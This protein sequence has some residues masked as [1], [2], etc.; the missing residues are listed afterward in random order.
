[1]TTVQVAPTCKARQQVLGN[2]SNQ[3]LNKATTSHVCQF[4]FRYTTQMHQL[5]LPMDIYTLKATQ[6]TKIIWHA[7]LV[8]ELIELLGSPQRPPSLIFLCKLATKP[9]TYLLASHATTGR[10]RPACTSITCTATYQER[11][12]FMYNGY[13]KWVV[14]DRWSIISS[15]HITWEYIMAI[16]FQPAPKT[17]TMEDSKRH[18]TL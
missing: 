5:N 10:R 18:D 15:L 17:I 11:V 7:Y 8:T 4:L 9:S 6:V 1:M 12:T 14:L 16:I 13:L 2:S 3:S